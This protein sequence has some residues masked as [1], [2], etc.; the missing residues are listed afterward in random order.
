[1]LRNTE[2]PTNQAILVGLFLQCTE[3]IRL[4][5]ARIMLRYQRREG[6]RRRGAAG[7]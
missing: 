6:G 7:L 1:M 3:I 5:L 2:T 4:I